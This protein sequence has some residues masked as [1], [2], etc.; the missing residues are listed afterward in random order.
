MQNTKLGKNTNMKIF[1]K[2]KKGKET[3]KKNIKA[4]GKCLKMHLFGVISSK[5][6]SRVGR[7]KCTTN[8]PGARLQILNSYHN[9]ML[10]NVIHGIH[11]SEHLVPINIHRENQNNI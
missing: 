6:K 9:R 5:K 8:T 7:S 11:E 4:G 10:K 1:R 2:M 3:E